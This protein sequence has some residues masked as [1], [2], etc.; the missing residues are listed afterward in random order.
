[1]K[2]IHK[3]NYKTYTITLISLILSAISLPMLPEQIPIHFNA[4]GVADGYGSP[5]MIFLLPGIMLFMNL[6]A[7]FT[8]HA[9]PRASNYVVFSKH[10]YL[11]F[12]VMNIFFF[13]VQLYLITYALELIHFNLSN[14]LIIALGV[15][16]IIVGNLMPKVKQNFF[17]GIKTPWT[18]ADE[19]V[20]YATHRFA[21][22]LWFVVGILMC[23]CGFLPPVA[24]VPVLIAIT[25][26]AALVPMAYS[27]LIFKRN[28]EK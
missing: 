9:D 3:D 14:I 7:E 28:S 20:W 10:Y 16:F 4:Q 6:L 8:K 5:L 17:M 27:Y 26:I 25:L 2:L 12:L 15:L 19:Q 22:K 21:G 24:F 18:L 23:I 11:F 1:M 13:L